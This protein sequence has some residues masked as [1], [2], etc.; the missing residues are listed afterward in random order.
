MV[1]AGTF[2]L[3]MVGNNIFL[4][5][6]RLLRGSDILSDCL[7]PLQL[8]VLIIIPIP[9]IWILIVWDPILFVTAAIQNQWA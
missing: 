1:P 3:F 6:L 5:T 7:V 4:E 2:G 9:Q 8:L